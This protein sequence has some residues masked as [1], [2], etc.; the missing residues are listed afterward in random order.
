MEKVEKALRRTT[1]VV[2]GLLLAGALVQMFGTDAIAG[3]HRESRLAG[4]WRMQVTPKNCQ[5]GQA[6]PGFDVLLSFARGGTLTEVMNAQAF[7]PGQRT[8][9]LGV[10]DHE[11]G[12]RYKAVWDAFVLFDSPGP[13][14]YKRGVQRL[15]WEIRVDDDQATFD[16]TSQFL[17]ASGNLV[18]ATCANGTGTRF[19]DSQ[20]ED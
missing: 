16:A 6:G 8:A 11:R 18:F 7:Q 13:P 1:L 9:G 3:S 10:W 5:T 19:D 17:D 12:N 14:G 2:A 15:A 4:T 20:D